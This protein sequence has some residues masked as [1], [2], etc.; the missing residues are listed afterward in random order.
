MSGIDE[1][2]PAPLLD[3]A[4][5]GATRV[6]SLVAFRKRG[7]HGASPSPA[8]ASRRAS[9]SRGSS[10]PTAWSM[11][12][13]GSPR[14]ANRRGTVNTVKSAGSATDTSSQS[15]GAETRASG[16]GRTEYALHVVRSFAFWL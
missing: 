12:A 14:S 10:E 3:L 8:A 7:G 13:W 4:R 1:R 2:L 15:S 6:G 5:D 16:N 9:S 11:A